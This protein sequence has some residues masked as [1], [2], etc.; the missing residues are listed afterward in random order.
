MKNVTRTNIWTKGNKFKVNR[1]CLTGDLNNETLMSMGK[2][3]REKLF[4]RNT[5]FKIPHHGS[6]NS[7][8]IFNI[9]NNQI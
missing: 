6:E 4:L 3:T 1:I 2:T 9:D 7:N 8:E 5:F